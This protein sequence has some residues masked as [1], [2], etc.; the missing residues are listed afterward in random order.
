MYS[1]ILFV[2]TN[3]AMLHINNYPIKSQSRSA[4]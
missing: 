3:N 2:S 4:H 1:L